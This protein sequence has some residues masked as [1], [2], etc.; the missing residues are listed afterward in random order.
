MIRILF[1][2]DEPNVLDGLRRMLRVK[3]HDWQMAFAGGGEAAL[4]AMR[5]EPF[6]VV[7]SDMR[8]PIMDGA[9]LLGRIRDQWP[10]TVRLVLSGQSDQELT[11]R[12][13]GPAHQYLTKPCDPKALETTIN[14]AF[15]SQAK[16]RDK[17]VR[18]LVAGFDSLPSLPDAYAEL[19]AEMNSS[20]ACIESAGRI[21]SRD[22]GMST[23]VLQLINSSFFGM[24]VHVT[25]V[26]HATALLGLSI[27]RPLVL[28]AN[29]FRQFENKALGSFRLSSMVDH[30][31]CVAMHARQIAVM[32]NA[33]SE[34]VDNTL[35]AGLMHDIGQMML[36]EN[37]PDE[38]DHT[39]ELTH[40]TGQRLVDM[41]RKAFGVTHAELGGHLLSLWGLPSDITQAVEFHHDPQLVVDDVFAPL[42][43]VHAAE[44]CVARENEG[45]P[46]NQGFREE[47]FDQIGLTH[48]LDEWRAAWESPARKATSS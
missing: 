44:V 43:A 30:S 25:D 39:I 5:E 15:S 34:A 47:Y 45:A 28:S 17:T 48:R 32:E 21:I 13:I 9:E 20:E 16:A 18:E 19:V 26:E 46:E 2:D 31:L 24:P 23:K 14:K 40:T 27:I 12:A 6:D 22:I 42:A 41:E 38:Y 4:A 36:A 10:D 37:F 1:V 33:P 11:I 3:R 29:V 8:M 7:V 35:L